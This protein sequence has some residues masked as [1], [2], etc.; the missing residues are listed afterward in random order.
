MKR[1]SNIFKFSSKAQIEMVGLMFIVIIIGVVIA[2]ALVYSARG[3]EEELVHER[4]GEKVISDNLVTVLAE[5]F[6]P[7]CNVDY[8]TLVWDCASVFVDPPDPLPPDW[9]N[10][11]RI[12]CTDFV[13]DLQELSCV[14]VQK[15]AVEILAGTL[16]VWGVS[17]DFNVS[18]GANTIF[19][20]TNL[21]CTSDKER[22]GSTPHFVPLYPVQGEA[23]IRLQICKN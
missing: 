4:F 22:E 3:V 21:D 19:H 16:D 10:Q 2:F 8:S 23:R 7:E 11:G 6:V 14:Y 15:V 18:R 5:T 13:T 1:Q 9:L 17:Y 20:Q 12:T